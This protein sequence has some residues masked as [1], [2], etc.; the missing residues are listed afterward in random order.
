MNI[1]RQNKQENT[2]I[3]KNNLTFFFLKMILCSKKNNMKLDLINVKRLELNKF[4]E[5]KVGTRMLGSIVA[6]PVK[7]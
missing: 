1:L 7:P 2:I 5:V 4:C 3:I 6:E